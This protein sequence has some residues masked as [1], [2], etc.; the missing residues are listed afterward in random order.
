MSIVFAIVPTSAYNLN[1][2]SYTARY[3]HCYNASATV[4]AV[5]VAK[6]GREVVGVSVRQMVGLV[7]HRCARSAS[8]VLTAPDWPQF[9]LH[10]VRRNDGI[11]AMTRS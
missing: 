10:K 2:N 8:V 6:R 3:S 7:W 11:K 9:R 1:E 4:R 5:N